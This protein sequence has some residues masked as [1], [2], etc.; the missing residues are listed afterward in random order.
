VSAAIA[1]WV[2]AWSRKDV[3]GYLAAYAKNFAVP[4]GQ[5]RR[6]WEKERRA[7]IAGKSWIDVKIEAL[8]ITVDGNIAKARFRQ[9]YRS[10]KLTENSSKTLTLVKTNQKWLIQQ[11]R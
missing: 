2:A 7:R 6:Q 8:E 11:E 3:D 9:N 10:D 5:S 1:S 4:G